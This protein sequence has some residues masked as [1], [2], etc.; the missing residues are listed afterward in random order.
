MI[1][2]EDLDPKQLLTLI[3]ARKPIYDLNDAQYKNRPVVEQLWMEIAVKMNSDVIDCKRKW[4]YL[5]KSYARYLRTE[6]SADSC[7]GEKK[8]KWYMADAMSFL[9]NHIQVP[10]SGS[11]SVYTDDESQSSPSNLN[12]SGDGNSPVPSKRSRT[13]PT[14]IGEEQLIKKKEEPNI[15]HQ[16]KRESKN[17]ALLTDTTEE[18]IF[19]DI[20]TSRRKRKSS[21]DYRTTQKNTENGNALFFKSL[22]ADYENLSSRGQRTF[23]AYMLE[24]MNELQEEEEMQQEE[25]MPY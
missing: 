9:R 3:K 24:K 11:H 16:R 5:R 23:R 18:P 12:A 19:E 7:D 22:L 13:T 14:E 6:R 2:M 15:E 8:K 21:K 4:S 20:Q 25:E 1:A 17:R 10:R